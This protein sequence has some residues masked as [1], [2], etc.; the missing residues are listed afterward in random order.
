MIF[1]TE[2]RKRNEMSKSE[3]VKFASDYIFCAE[4]INTSMTPESIYLP[5][6][7]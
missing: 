7:I 6:M 3:M 2:Y 5:S 1:D 4:I